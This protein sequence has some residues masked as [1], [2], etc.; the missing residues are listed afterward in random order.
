[1]TPREHGDAVARLVSTYHRA[2]DSVKEAGRAWY[3]SAAEHAAALGPNGAAVIAA[4]S[5]RSAWA[6]NVANARCV[7]LGE[8]STPLRAFRRN[9]E[10][11][12]ALA[13]GAELDDVLGPAPKVRAFAAAIA[14]DPD[15][16]VVDRH[17][18]RAATG[19][20]Y[21]TRGLGVAPYRAVAEVY[22]D[23]AGLVAETPRDLQA[24]I[25]VA[26]RGSSD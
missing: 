14:G 6:E 5:P 26:Q 17:A 23:A 19:A 22:R 10:R 12:R 2:D 3:P 18:Y 24:I 16:V 25:W 20:D 8:C 4:L 1:M 9:V 13:A 7:V 11:A 15:A 21:P